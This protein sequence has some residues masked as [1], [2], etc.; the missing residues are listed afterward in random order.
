MRKLI[1][2]R[3]PKGSLGIDQELPY[4]FFYVG[5]CHA[6]RRWQIALYWK[7]TP[8]PRKV[9]E[10]CWQRS[11]VLYWELRFKTWLYRR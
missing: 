10:I 11:W 9:G 2:F 7:P 1:A 4:A 5:W 8:P 3:A 6:S